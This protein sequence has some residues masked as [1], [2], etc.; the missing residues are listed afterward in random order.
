MMVLSIFLEEQLLLKYYLIK[1]SILLKIQKMIYIKEV[2]RHW[3]IIFLGK[4]FSSGALT[5]EDKSPE[6]RIGSVDLEMLCVV[7]V[8]MHGLFL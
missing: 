3:F 6:L 7:I 5:H 2:L 4:N 1:Y 8:N